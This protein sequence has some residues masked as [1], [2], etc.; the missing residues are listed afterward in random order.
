MVIAIQQMQKSVVRMKNS[1]EPI[2]TIDAAD[3]ATIETKAAIA[4]LFRMLFPS[5]AHRLVKVNSTKIDM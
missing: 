1:V 3:A 4:S 2:T 5:S